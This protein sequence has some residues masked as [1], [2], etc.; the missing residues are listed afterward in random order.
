MVE[1]SEKNS[2]YFASLE[3]KISETKL[4]SR[5]QINNKLNTDQKEIISETEKYYKTLYA[6]RET[7]NSRYNLF[8]KTMLKLN[9]VEKEQ[10]DGKE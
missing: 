4:I 1:H 7:Q 5:L 3:K 6:K 8:D 2:T 10:C 9:Q